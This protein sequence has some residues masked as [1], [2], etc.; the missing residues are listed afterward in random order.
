MA[1]FAAPCDQPSY[2]LLSWA[3]HAGCCVHLS[4]SGASQGDNGRLRWPVCISLAG[5]QV[6]LRAHWL[7]MTTQADDCLSTIRRCCSNLRRLVKF[8]CSSVRIAGLWHPR[9]LCA[10]LPTHSRPRDL[11]A[12]IARGAAWCCAARSAA[13]CGPPHHLTPCC[14][15][16]SRGNPRCLG[17]WHV[18]GQTWRAACLPPPPPAG[19][20]RQ[21]PQAGDRAGHPFQLHG[22]Q[23]M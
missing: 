15:H 23:D 9:Q 20:L 4:V 3:H 13:S 6:M 18:A 21:P 19:E 8:C 12:D 16:R 5:Q 7:S 22:R 14:L 2:R 1:T 10:V 11:P 17:R